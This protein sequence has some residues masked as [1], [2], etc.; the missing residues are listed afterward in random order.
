MNS[1][2]VSGFYNSDDVLV[3]VTVKHRNDSTAE[4]YNVTVAIY[5]PTVLKF[6]N[7]SAA[8]NSSY[9]VATMSSGNGVV[10]KASRPVY[11]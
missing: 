2:N 8:T 7:V 1:T 5:L 3:R 4:G 6:V 10:L 11:W 9:D